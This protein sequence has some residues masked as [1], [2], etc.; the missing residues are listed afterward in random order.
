[1]SKHIAQVRL[2]AKQLEELNEKPSDAAIMAKLLHGLQTKFHHV[3]TIWRSNRDPSKKIDDLCQLLLEEETSQDVSDLEVEVNNIDK[4]KNK[5]EK[6]DEQLAKKQAT[7]RRDKSKIKCFNCG[8]RGHFA[9][10]CRMSKK[11]DKSKTSDQLASQKKKIAMRHAMWRL[12]LFQTVM[13]GLLTVVH[14]C[15]WHHNVKYLPLLSKR[16]QHFY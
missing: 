11:D 16:R 2:L 12:T 7:D 4:Y 9:R 6:A 1:M 5:K 14:L 13:I 10:E 8:K 15:I 3:R